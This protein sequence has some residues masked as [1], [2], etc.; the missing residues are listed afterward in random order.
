MTLV[1]LLRGLPDGVR[2]DDESGAVVDGRPDPRRAADPN[3][4]FLTMFRRDE[5]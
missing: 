5:W 4:A 3:S 2:R 1:A